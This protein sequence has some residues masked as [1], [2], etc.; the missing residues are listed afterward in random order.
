MV[1]ETQI[2]RTGHHDPR[3][4]RENLARQHIPPSSSHLFRSETVNTQARL[5]PLVTDV[6]D[7]LLPSQFR[8]TD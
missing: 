2:R 3:P 5:G 4:C 1:D 7:M 6:I 8:P